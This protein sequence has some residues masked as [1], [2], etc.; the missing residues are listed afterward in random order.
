MK[1]EISKEQQKE[2]DRITARL[3]EIVE[4]YITRDSRGNPVEEYGYL[5]RCKW[6]LTEEGYATWDYAYETTGLNFKST[7]GANLVVCFEDGAYLGLEKG[8]HIFG[9]KYEDPLTEQSFYD[10]FEEIMRDVP[11]RAYEGKTQL[12]AILGIHDN[13]SLEAYQDFLESNEYGVDVP[14]SIEEMVE[15]VRQTKYQ[16]ILM[17]INF[18]KPGSDDISAGQTIYE[19]VKDR[20]ERGDVMYMSISGK[21]EAVEKARGQGIP[22]QMKPFRIR[23]WLE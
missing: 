18:K 21:I 2:V 7:A 16:I 1:D 14:D 19:I 13:L 6:P 3:D 22:T 4:P 17:D 5:R 10:V 9:A 11:I 15:K 8:F 12:R 20:V 23:E